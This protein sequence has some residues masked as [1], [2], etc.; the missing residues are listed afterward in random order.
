MERLIELFI[1]T[2]DGEFYDRGGLLAAYDPA[3]NAGELVRLTVQLCAG[4]PAFNSD[5][6]LLNPDTTFAGTLAAAETI[7]DN[8]FNWYDKGT[9]LENLT[10][11]TAISELSV[12]SEAAPRQLGAVR[13]NAG[14]VVNFCG[15]TATEGGYRLT[16]ADNEFNPA[17][18]TPGAD[19]AQGAALE[20]LEQPI[21]VSAQNDD[22]GR[23]TGLFTGLLDAANPVYESMIEGHEDIP[24]CRI[25]FSI[26]QDGRA[27]FRARRYFDCLGAM[28]M[29]KGAAYVHSD[30]WR[31]ADSRYIKLVDWQ[32]PPEYQFSED[33]TNWHDQQQDADL[34]Y[35]ERRPGGQWGPAVK[36]KIGPTGAAAG[37]ATP[38]VTVETLPAGS[39]ATASVTA[40]GDDTAKVFSFN[41]GIPKGADG[42]NGTNGA[43]GAAGADGVS[44]YTYVAYASDAS[45][46][47][48]SLT[49]TN[50]LKYRAEI[51]T[52][53]AI[54]TPDAED[55]AGATWV[56][57][58]GDD[59]TGAGDMTKSVYDTNDDGIVDHAAAADA[60]GATTAA[61]VAD[62]VA[63]AHTHANKATLDK[64]AEA[65]GKLTF[66][67]SEIGG[68]SNWNDIT[69]KPETF[70]PSAHN[71]AITDV[72]GLEDALQNA[73]S[74]KSVNGQLPDE[75]G[76]VT[77][78][79]GGAVDESRLLPENPANGDIPCFD[80]TATTGGG[81]DANTRLLLQPST[82]DHGIVDQAAGNA[83]PV[84]LE[85]YN[86]TVDEEGNMVFDGSNSYLKIPANT[87][88]SDFFNGTDEWTLDI[89]YN[90]ASKSM[91]CLFGCS[92][93]LRMDFLLDSNG[94]LQIGGGPNL[95]TGWPFNEDVHLT[96]EIYKDGTVW[97]YTIFRNGSVVTT[98]TWVNA[99]WRS[100][101]QYI[102]WEGE[103]DSRKINGKIKALRLTSGALHKG[104]AFQ[105]DYPWTKPQTVGE[106]GKLNKSALVQN[107]NGQT[108]DS[109]GVV[110][111][112]AATVSAAGLMAAADKVKLDALQQAATYI[113]TATD[114]DTYKTAGSYFL[115]GAVHTNG[116]LTDSYAGTLVVVALAELQYATQYFTQLYTNKTFVRTYAQ[117]NSA[118]SAWRR[119]IVDTDL[120]TTTVAG[121]MAAADKAAIA[122]LT[123]HG[124]YPNALAKSGAV[125]FNEVIDHGMYLIGGDTPHLNYP[126][127][128]QQNGGTLQVIRNGNYL[129][130]TFIPLNI[131]K[132]F[133][134]SCLNALSD[135][136]ERT[137]SAWRR[138]LTDTDITEF[139]DRPGYFKLPGGI[140][141]QWGAV[142]DVSETK[143]F[144]VT[145]PLAFP[146]LGWVSLASGTSTK[147]ATAA[148]FN[149]ANALKVMT[150]VTGEG[151]FAVYWIAIGY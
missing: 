85:N 112:P 34:Y 39:D 80:V 63:K 88:P 147:V 94:L 47:G 9:L 102:G 79:T 73:G 17:Q 134:R 44:S 101:A 22:S 128:Y 97:K 54:E 148:Y 48:F 151:S 24:G 143:T 2:E 116:P 38:T 105:S 12:A 5:G 104:A 124:I 83:A 49:P 109:S 55:F 21:V 14:T 91:Q 86:V 140:I 136:S 113:N 26:Y 89:V 61:Q 53:T 36:M 30:S 126:E 145:L 67:G 59:G 3:I 29:N 51:H 31:E 127:T 43:D 50:A 93:S 35:H 74:V 149:G 132:A 33:G 75:S 19:F 123:T 40:S 20:V 41:F 6:A 84:T 72:T 15:W 100:V 120:A 65:D 71:H 4:V 1:N 82:S 8:N 130:Q 107:V 135:S 125:D 42:Q 64:L 111:L 106:W 92:S 141:V 52:T 18:F 66:D 57:Y 122:G 10:T 146:H 60:V 99:D 96:F 70:P 144:D 137:F 110:T 118:W 95:G 138:S 45:G 68:A 27:V 90:V 37:F 76:N 81:N 131:N 129:T 7:I 114:F 119:I 13:L 58:I 62:A 16:L 98:G 117:D 121:L 32:A 87:L 25:E 150:N 78:E 133:V 56:K 23:A 28:A 77:V 46:T 103:S 108:P 139:K 11:G 115:K 142:L 69:G